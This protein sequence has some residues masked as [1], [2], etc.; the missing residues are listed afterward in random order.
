MYWEKYQIEE[1][2]VIQIIFDAKIDVVI[3]TKINN[4]IKLNLKAKNINYIFNLEKTQYIDVA[5]L[6]GIIGNI[7]RIRRSCGQVF[8]VHVPLSVKNLVKLTGLQEYL[9]E[10][11]D[12]QDAIHY[13]KMHS[14]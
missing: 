4:L 2:E 8:F 9:V 14:R 7:Q 13:F 5:G 6:G 10:K 11:K 12:M 1:M 3:V